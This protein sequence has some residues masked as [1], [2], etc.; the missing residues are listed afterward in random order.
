MVLFQLSSIQAQDK[1]FH[2][3]L[4]F[5]QSNMEGQGIISSSDKV[6]DPRF[7][8]FQA[9]NCTNLNRTKEKWY[10]AI[11]PT[12]QSWS[13]LSPADYFGKTMVANLPDSITVGIINVSI[14][15]CDIRIFDKDIYENFD[16]TYKDTWFTD[17]V[18][19]YDWNP[20]KYLIDLAKLAQHDGVIKGIL[21]HQGE[22]NTGDENWP[23][24]VKKIYN[25]MLAD[26]SLSADSVPLFA[27]EVLSATGNC[28]ASMNT[29]I[30]R[31]DDTIPTAHII[32][33]SGCAGK[34]NAHF[35]SDGYRKLGRRYAV[36]MLSL[37]GL[38]ADYAETECGSIGN[39]LFVN[40]EETASNGAYIMSKQ[41]SIAVPTDTTDV[42]KLT[43]KV[44]K[45]TTYNVYGR[46]NNTNTS[47]DSFWMKIDNGSYE[48]FENMTTKGW[49]WLE[50]KSVDL[51]PGNHT[52]S[53]AFADD[54][55]KFDKLA[56]KN[57][58]RKP[59]D[60]GE[61]A[62]KLCIANIT[63]NG[64]DILQNGYYLEQSYPNPVTSGYV[65][66]TFSIP[67]TCYVSLK[68]YNS[69]GIEITEIV[70]NNYKEG[71]YSVQLKTDELLAGLYYY[72]MK[73]EEFTSTKK[74]MVMV[75]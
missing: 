2:I 51:T 35:N 69:N 20:Y 73:T 24:Y 37:M 11:P 29:I 23:K 75:K 39:K 58:H 65:K 43:I 34:D 5:G 62:Q 42:L 30:N 66:F 63:P 56:V 54:S 7:K 21:L 4:C 70:G 48:Y 49:E 68:L 53:F 15:G 72:T 16:S 32:S 38:E 28:C 67:K 74:M 50:L 27:G 10:T 41:T 1:N 55:V 3:Y 47:H 71:T 40:A 44:V 31:L 9:L 33:S 46:F 17:L 61:E 12:C 19:G 14:G 26:L 25:D 18:K 13:K 60:V 8:T 45:D 6:V 64:N 59:V 22:T 52:F 36:T 57:T